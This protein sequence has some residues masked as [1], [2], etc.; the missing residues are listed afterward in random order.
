MPTPALEPVPAWPN[1]E[2]PEPLIARDIAEQG[3]AMCP[4]FLAASDVQA[5]LQAVQTD[6]SED[7][8]QTAGIGRGNDYQTNR[9]VRQ[10]Q[11]RWLAAR[12]AAES[13]FLARMEI[14]RMAVNREL[15]AGLFDY[16]AHFA[17]YPPGAFYKKH[18]DA[19]QGNTNRRLSTVLYLNFD[20]QPSD[21]GELRCFDPTDNQRILF[22]LAPRAGT[23]VV[24]ESD[25][26]W[27]EVLPAQ[28]QR[29]SIAGW[30]R[31]NGSTA[32]RVDPAH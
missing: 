25:R 23:L 6:Q 11:I 16:E 2:G 21:G 3:Y 10:D 30:F 29:F 4:D 24:F 5:L 17:V 13:R 7:R 27:H 8:L 19:F 32:G 31:V 15:F 9:Y 12:S 14:L 22:D 28:R 20:W 26:Y 18:V 1:P